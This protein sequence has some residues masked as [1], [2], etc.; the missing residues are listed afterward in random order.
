MRQFLLTNL[1]EQNGH[2]AWRVNLEAISAHLDDI[3][4]FPNFDT[5]YEG[6][7]LF[8]GGASSAYIRYKTQIV[9][10]FEQVKY[11]LKKVQ[12]ITFKA[13]VF[14]FYI[15]MKIGKYL[16]K[17]MQVDTK[18]FW[19]AWTDHLVSFS[20]YKNVNNPIKN[21]RGYLELIVNT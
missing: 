2:Y 4:S 21:D 19:D 20:D 15:F 16:T 12:I 3:M 1:V 10:F 11:F 6:P 9:N 13:K 5:G 17:K 14:R 8:L 18:S 7:T